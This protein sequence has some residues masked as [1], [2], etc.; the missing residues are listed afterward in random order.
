MYYDLWDT[1]T[2]NL[3]ESFDTEAAALE[4]VR[5]LAQD[6]GDA[7]IDTLTLIEGQ[8]SSTAKRTVAYG[9]ALLDR[10]RAMAAT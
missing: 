1:D 9:R 5:D 6:C 4:M 3:L 2:S 8:E 7:V 10:A